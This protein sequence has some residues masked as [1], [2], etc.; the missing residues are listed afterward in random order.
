MSF[1]TKALERIS[2]HLQQDRPEFASLLKPG[3]SLEAIQAQ[4]KNLPF[5]LPQEVCE[6][7][8][9][10][11][12]INFESISENISNIDYLPFDI[13]F[14]PHLD[15][16]PLEYAIE[17]SLDI[18]KFRHEYSSPKDENCHKPWFPIFGSDDLEYL[19][20]FGDSVENETSPIMHC[21]LG[22]GTLPRF[23][24]PSLTT[25]MFIVAE[26]YETGAYYLDENSEYTYCKA[27]L[28]EDKKQVA[29]I[30]R[31]YCS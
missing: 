29:K 7:Y 15:F 18:E 20:V 9:W 8:Q 22:G 16:L 21:H 3:L 5:C 6:L 1:L 30:K 12:G 11:N 2:E 17:E 26:C 13:S 19:I 31:K 14:I 28:E 25:F 24:Y 23:Q 4:T 27:Y 10:R